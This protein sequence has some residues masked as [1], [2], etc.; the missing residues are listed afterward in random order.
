[1]TTQKKTQEMGKPY[2]GNNIIIGNTA[3]Q[4]NI[5]E[6]HNEQDGRP[7]LHSEIDHSHTGQTRPHQCE[8][9]V[10]KIRPVHK[11]DDKNRHIDHDK[12]QGDTDTIP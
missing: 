5:A 11:D 3:N 7:D 6:R 8:L 4:P 12:Q 1:M 10:E 2:S 9:V